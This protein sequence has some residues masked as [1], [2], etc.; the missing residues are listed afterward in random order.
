MEREKEERVRCFLGFAYATIG[1]ERGPTIH[2][3]FLPLEK[4]GV[5]WS[6]VGAESIQ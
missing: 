2:L 3:P 5:Q 4:A 1:K 6:G